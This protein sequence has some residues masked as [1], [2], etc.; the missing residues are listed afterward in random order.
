MA[1][2]YKTFIDYFQI[3]E[4]YT[5][6]S[7]CIFSVPVRPHFTPDQTKTPVDGRALLGATPWDVT[8]IYKDKFTIAGI[9]SA[10][11]AHLR[12]GHVSLD[13]I[14]PVQKNR[15]QDWQCC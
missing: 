10:M 3:V 4:E 7:T 14:H 1:P 5:K 11:R 8:V 15:N 9:N 6:G 13:K 12:F 2:W